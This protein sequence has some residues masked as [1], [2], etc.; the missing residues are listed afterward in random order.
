MIHCRL[1]RHIIISLGGEL[2]LRA[3]IAVTTDPPASW[4]TCTCMCRYAYTPLAVQKDGRSFRFQKGGQHRGTKSLQLIAWPAGSAEIGCKMT[5]NASPDGQKEEQSVNPVHFAKFAVIFRNKI[6]GV[7]AVG[8]GG[9]TLH[10]HSNHCSPLAP[11]THPNME[12]FFFKTYRKLKAVKL[13]VAP[14]SRLQNGYLQITVGDVIMTPPTFLYSQW[15]AC[16]MDCER[17]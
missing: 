13:T 15:C 6:V 7:A 17:T 2:Q 5:T 9:H 16:A 10:S 4:C 1:I 14:T 12:A 3:L 8:V 11:P